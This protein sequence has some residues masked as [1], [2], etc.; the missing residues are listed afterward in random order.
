MLIGIIG[1]GVV[2]QTI[3]Q[4]FSMQNYQTKWYDKFK[5][6]STTIDELVDCEYVFI[7]VPTDTIDNICDTS[8]VWNAVDELNQ[9]LYPGV[10]IIKSTVIPGTTEKLIKQY[11]NLRLNFMPEF[12]HQDNALDDFLHQT[13]TLIVGSHNTED[14]ELITELHKPFCS[15]S[16]KISPTEA[17]LVKYFA[18][19]FNS[20]RIVF[21]NAY[22]EVCSKLGVNYDTMLNSAVSL[23]YIQHD[24]YLKCSPL[25]RGFEGKCLPKDIKAFNTF[26]KELNLPISL[27]DAIIN[28]NE[29][30]K[31][32]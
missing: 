8:N 6:N 21:A 7:C 27:F 24:F 11:P 3:V 31:K 9:I 29:H 15:N 5:D 22:Y 14:F 18:N 2:G 30:Y 17:E 10:I 23:P 16:I 12:L 28:D 20:L 4:A 19:T 26:I 13:D 25:M 32:Q 1:Y